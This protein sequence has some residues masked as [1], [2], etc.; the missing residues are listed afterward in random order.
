[1][2]A[3]VNSLNLHDAITKTFEHN[4]ALRSFAYQLKAQEGRALQAGMSASPELDLTVED[5]FGKGD[6][7]GTDRAQTTLSIGWVIEGDIRQGYIDIAHAGS[8]ALTAQANFKRLDSAAE[9]ARLY[10][11]ILETQAHQS[12][13]N[14]TVALAE[15]TVLAVKKRVSAGKSPEAE[16]ARAQAEAAY[17]LLRREDVEHELSSAIH[18]LAA[19]WG[20]TQPKFSRVEGDIF[21]LPTTMSFETLK[22]YLEKSPE[23]SHLLSEKRLKQA[24]LTFAEA[25]NG[26]EWRVNLGV[27]RYEL[28]GDQALVAGITIPFGERSRN[29]GRINEARANLSQMQAKEDE[30]RVR[31]ETV[32][33]VLYQELQHG[34]HRADTYRNKIIPRLEKALKQTRRA[35]DLG[36]YSYLEWRTVQ[37]ELLD[38]RTALLETSIDT[39]L[40]A[41]EI[42]RLTGVRITQP[43]I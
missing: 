16:L 9:T 40:K 19:Q 30:L 41:I 20:E 27:R 1:V 21:S 5:A 15:E 3:V 6:F 23:F 43:T 18:L 29:A 7:E 35:Y 22:T 32:L 33:Y 8:L 37:A 12:N 13:A 2:S 36:R 38:A 11:T 10:F 25:Q 42:E 39:H 26:S 24:E 4:P 28:T 31:F 17:S 14:E 34:F